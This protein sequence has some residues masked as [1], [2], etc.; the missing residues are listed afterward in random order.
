MSALLKAGEV[1]RL[2]RRPQSIDLIDHLSEANAVVAEAKRN[3]ERIVAGAKQEIERM[4]PQVRKKTY[5]A[6]Y[7]KGYEEGCREGREAGTRDG[8]SEA[9]ES[10]LAKFDEQHTI[11]VQDLE[12]V[13]AEVEADRER[14]LIAARQD[15][16]E[17]S[18]RLA[19]KLTF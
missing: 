8:H 3:A 12:R 4:V 10:S 7:E 2:S 1:A 15:V 6:A 13:I 9:L 14:L 5:D 19:T 18:V 11:I 17:F 16:L